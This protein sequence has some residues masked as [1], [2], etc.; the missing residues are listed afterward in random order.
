MPNYTYSG[1]AAQ[2][3][4]ALRLAMALQFKG[5]LT[6]KITADLAKDGASRSNQSLNQLLA[7]L[8]ADITKYEAQAAARGGVSRIVRGSAN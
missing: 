8:N 6:D 2:A 3:T 5:E 4:P 1:Y 7:S